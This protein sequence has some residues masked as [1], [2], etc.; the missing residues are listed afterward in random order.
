MIATRQSQEPWLDAIERH[1]GLSAEA[2]LTDKTLDHNRRAALLEVL[3]VR[4]QPEFDDPAVQ[5]G[6]RLLS[7]QSQLSQLPDEQPCLLNTVGSLRPVLI[8]DL[9]FDAELRGDV[10]LAAKYFEETIKLSRQNNNQHLLQVGTSHLA[11]VQLVQGQLQAASQTHELAIIE[12]FQTPTVALAHAGLGSIYYEWGDLGKAD[13]HFQ[14][15]LPLARAWNQW[16]A[17]FDITIGLAH[18]AKRQGHIQSA[19]SMLNDFNPQNEYL[20]K[21]THTVQFSWSGDA[22]AATNWLASHELSASTTPTP[23]NESLLLEVVRILIAIDQLDDALILTKN[24]HVSAKEGG[25][26]HYVIQ[27]D[28]LFAKIFAIQG[29]TSEALEALGNALLI[30]ETEKYLS[31]F[32][33]EGNT[34]RALLGRIQGN[35]S[36]K[37]IMA[38]FTTTPDSVITSEPASERHGLLSNR[39]QE[40]LRLISDGLTNQEIA[41]LLVI[42]I[43]TVKTHV[44]NIFNKLGVTSRTQAIARAESTGLLPRR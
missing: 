12:A 43:T 42:S 1:Y 3:V 33:D 38:G 16:D 34:I 41:S 27:A 19:I 6:E 13:L 2:A 17:L 11:H 8:Y 21:L 14:A 24:I 15:A 35:A 36:A 4:Q 30:A 28:I 22:P 32:V 44:G 31:I 10:Q 7:I 25:R 20:L 40:I 9:G 39:E 23:F 37:R 26:Y 29:K 18:I 5:A